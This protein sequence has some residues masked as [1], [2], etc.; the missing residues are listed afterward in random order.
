MLCLRLHTE[1]IHGKCHF[2]LLNI[3]FVFDV[4]EAQSYLMS[5][6]RS[7]SRIKKGQEVQLLF[8][9][10]LKEDQLGRGYMISLTGLSVNKARLGQ[11]LRSPGN[12]TCNFGIW[13]LAP[14]FM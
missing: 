1:L 5:L 11:L 10:P 9:V 6:S 14:Q 12:G 2:V 8:C 4:S 13:H 3:N 7:G